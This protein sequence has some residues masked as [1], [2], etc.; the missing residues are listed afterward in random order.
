MSL[1]IYEIITNYKLEI[2]RHPEL[3]S[4]SPA[5]KGDAETSSAR[6]YI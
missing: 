4:V 2:T 1:Q 5:I 6:Q 3:V